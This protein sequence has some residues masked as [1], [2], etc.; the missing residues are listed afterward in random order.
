MKVDGDLYKK[1]KIKLAREEM[2]IKNYI[3]KLIIED[4]NKTEQKDN[5]KE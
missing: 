2:T 5:E 4:I 1:M 3:A